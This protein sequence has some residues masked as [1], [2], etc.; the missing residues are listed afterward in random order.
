MNVRMVDVARKA[1]VSKSTVSQFLNGRFDYMSAETRDRIKQAVDELGF[2]PNALARSLKKKQTYTIATIVSNILNPFSTA[3]TRGAEDCCNKNGFDLIL[4]N[5]DDRPAKEKEYIETLVAKQVDGLIVSTT[6]KNNDLLYTV[7]KRTPITI[8]GRSVPNLNC[9]TVRVDSRAGIKLAVEHLVGLGHRRLALFVLPHQEVNVSPRRERVLAFREM[10]GEFGLPLRPEWIVEV[11]NRSEE[12]LAETV[13]GV[14]AA[15][16]PPTAFIGAN[17]LMSIA[18]FKAVKRQLGLRIPE[19]IALL[20]FDD[21]EWA[22]LLDPPITVVAQPAYEM[23]YM[24]AELVIKR[25]R[26]KTAE[27]K[28]QFMMYQPELIVRHS[29][30]E[31]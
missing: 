30:G 24:A 11:S 21:W 27:Y 15:P 8:L 25:I 23:G 10:A 18:L 26:E 6:E 1:G 14:L 7:N 2:V 31:K 29:C 12:A 22:N 4:C 20:S 17:D 28:S 3:T 9:D 5:A 19:D 13:R 16:E